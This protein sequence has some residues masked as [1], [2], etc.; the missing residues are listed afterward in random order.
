MEIQVASQPWANWVIPLIEKK[1]SLEKEY[2][3]W[4]RMEMARYWDGQVDDKPLWKGRRGHLLQFSDHIATEKENAGKIL[5]K[6]KEKERAKNQAMTNLPPLR[7][8]VLD[9]WLLGE[10][11]EY[12]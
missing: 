8:L 11:Y 6:S 12:T 2:W 4:A 10:K 9:I 3:G 7:N 5:R 1:Y